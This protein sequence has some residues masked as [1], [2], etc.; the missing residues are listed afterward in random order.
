MPNDTHA[1][2]LLNLLFQR[3]G[4]LPETY[5]IIGFDDSPI[6]REAV[7]PTSTVGQQISVIAGEAMEILSQQM[8]E[9]KKRR[10]I[11]I[12]EPVH[13]IIPPVLI[14]RGTTV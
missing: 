1:N 2:V 8:N 4:K 3:Y 11:P 14:R 12:K 6:S 13:R 9:R 10:P 5:Q 7:I